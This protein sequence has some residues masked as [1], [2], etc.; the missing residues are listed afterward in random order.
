MEQGITEEQTHCLV[1]APEVNNQKMRGGKPT[2]LKQNNNPLDFRI[3]VFLELLSKKK[4][5]W[6]IHGFVLSQIKGGSTA[7]DGFYLNFCANQQDWISDSQASL[8]LKI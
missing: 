6:E 7:L 5:S 8:S 1:S 2:N 4:N 3:P